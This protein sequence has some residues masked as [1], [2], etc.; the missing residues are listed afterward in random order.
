LERAAN[1]KDVS[2]NQEITDRLE[3]S[4][5]A[6]EYQEKERARDTRI[7]DLLIS[8]S[9]VNGNAERALMRG[10]LDYMADEFK[11]DTSWLHKPAEREEKAK[12][13]GETVARFVRDVMKIL[14][15]EEEK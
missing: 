2:I 6:Q 9:G 5:L 14:H 15:G 10:V 12:Q 3:F 13:M 7:V 1:L 8:V 11:G 4:F